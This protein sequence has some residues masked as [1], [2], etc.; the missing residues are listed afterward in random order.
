[1]DPRAAF[2]EWAGAP[3]G[4]FQDWQAI[5]HFEGDELAAVAMMAGTEVHVAISHKWRHRLLTRDRIRALLAPLIEKRGYLTTTTKRGHK[6][7]FLRRL[8][9]TPTWSEGELEH[10]ILTELP[11]ER[12]APCRP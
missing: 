2:M 5:S 3:P 4:S 9:F 10:M 6:A 7:S 8:G 11:F 1:M 12:T